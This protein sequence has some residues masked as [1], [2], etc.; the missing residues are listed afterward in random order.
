MD[1][2]KQREAAKRGGQAAQESGA[3]KFDTQEAQKAGKIGG[4]ATA[5]K[6]GEEFYSEIGKKGSEKS[7][8]N[9]NKK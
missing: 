7:R 5:K 8:E 3:H 2:K 6:Y 1:S 9:R 4:K